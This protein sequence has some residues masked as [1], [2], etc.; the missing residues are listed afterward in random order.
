MASFAR[1]TM[2]P[3][4]EESLQDKLFKLMADPFGTQVHSPLLPLRWSASD[5]PRL[6]QTPLLSP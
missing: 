2:F 4:E 6:L 1:D 5:K 3:R